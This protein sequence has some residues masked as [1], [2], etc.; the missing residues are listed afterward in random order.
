[1]DH[2]LDI[3]LEK[4]ILKELLKIV[5]K[6][7]AQFDEEIREAELK[8]QKKANTKVK[9]FTNFLIAELALLHYFIY[10]NLSWD[11][12]EPITVI[13][14]NIDIMVAYWFFIIKGKNFSPTA[15]KDQIFVERKYRHLLNSGVDV[16]KYQE[17]MEIRGDLKNR[18]KLLTRNPL[19]FMSACEEPIEIIS[20]RIPE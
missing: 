19:A 15:W 16:Q 11:I 12:M 8:L 20:N 2:S 18:L 5:D 17:Y 6:K 9:W 13:I 10:F 4:Q 7:V 3:K 1:M 14:M